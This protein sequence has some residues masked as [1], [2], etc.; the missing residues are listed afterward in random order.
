[1]IDWTLTTQ[2][3]PTQDRDPE[4]L[5]GSGTFVSP[6]R[7]GCRTSRESFRAAWQGLREAWGTQPNLRLQAAIGTG[8][9]ALG[10]WCRL[11]IREW[12]WVVLAIGLVL[13]AEL[14]NTAIERLVDLAA[15]LSPH[16]LAR[17]AKDLAAGA[18]LLASL[19]A[20][21]IGGLIFGPHLLGVLW[22]T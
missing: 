17:Q 20:M 7:F 19:V 1:M 15:D 6:P 2:K 16:P 3:V 9:A 5:L 12:L 8:V 13:V 14:L 11:S 21:S 22:S 10:V 4:S 18:V